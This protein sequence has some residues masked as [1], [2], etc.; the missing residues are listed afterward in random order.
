VR[1]ALE[2]LVHELPRAGRTT[3]R[4][5]TGHHRDRLE[6]IV[7]FLA[8]LE[9]FKRGLVDLDQAGNFG[10]LQIVWVGPADADAADLS[11]ADMYE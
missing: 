1:D 4:Q 10:E 11:T 7:R 3:F 2:E 8:V 9:L 5:L 6:I